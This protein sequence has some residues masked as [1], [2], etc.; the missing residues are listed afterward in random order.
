MDGK[1][2][3]EPARA[4]V[5]FSRRHPG[6]G[7]SPDSAFPFGGVHCS[8][9]GSSAF[10]PKSMPRPPGHG[11]GCLIAFETGCD[12]IALVSPAR[13]AR[14]VASGSLRP[15]DASPDVRVGDAARQSGGCR[16]GFGPDC[17]LTTR[18]GALRDGH[19]IGVIEEC[20][21]SRAGISEGSTGG[22]CGMNSILWTRILNWF[23]RLLLMP[24]G[25]GIP[26]SPQ[27]NGGMQLPN[28]ETWHS[29]APLQR[30]RSSGDCR[31]PGAGEVVRQEA[32]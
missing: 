20:P 25:T 12:A 27:F 2:S 1:T 23:G 32:C 7:S 15:R 18:L 8:A 29:L 21:R 31:R 16:R 6:C 10:G 5:A 30:F 22:I 26:I 19:S 13:L 14:Q 9:S 3:M 24:P 4:A 11:V 17:C 28:V